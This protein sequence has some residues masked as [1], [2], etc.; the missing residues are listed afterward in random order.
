[1]RV[2]DFAAAVEPLAEAAARN[3][4]NAIVLRNYAE[5]LS[6]LP[7]HAAEPYRAL[8]ATDRYLAIRPQDPWARSL[9][10]QAHLQA[11]RVLGEREWFAEAERIVLSC[12]DVG[13]PKGLVF[14]IAA[15]ARQGMNDDQG[16]LLHLD[17]CM[18]MGLDH[19]TVR[20]DRVTVLRALGRNREAH[21]ELMR[22]QQEAPMDPAVMNALRSSRPPR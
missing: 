15:A 9:S 12:L 22:A 4:N 6:Q 5:A 13:E 20:I 19:V 14:R 17:R 7:D 18:E 8:V 21:L 16:A 11:G 10:A 1:M 3:G 2:F